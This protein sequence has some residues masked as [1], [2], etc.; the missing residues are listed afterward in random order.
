MSFNFIQDLKCFENKKFSSKCDIIAL[1]AS[2]P[3]Y[4]DGIIMRLRLFSEII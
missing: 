4:Y 2:D 1:H 3:W